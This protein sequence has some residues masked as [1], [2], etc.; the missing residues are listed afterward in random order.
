MAQQLRAAGERI[1][2]LVLLD[3]GVLY[4][5]ALLFSLFPKEDL[6]I[7][8]VL[9]EGSSVQLT[10]FRRRSAP[11]RLIPPAAHDEQAGHIMHVF[12]SNMRAVLDYNAQP[13]DGPFTLFQASEPLVK[14]RH[15]PNYEWGHRCE[16]VDL[17]YVP[18]SHLTMI[19]EPHVAVL[20]EQLR[21]CLAT[22]QG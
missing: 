16:E 21:Q 6:G 14:S 13:Y 4:C 18:G 17:V 22:A 2:S 9:R 15:Q 8:E 20:A 7:F 11:A 12:I 19:Q 10:E 3:S 1:S 5:C